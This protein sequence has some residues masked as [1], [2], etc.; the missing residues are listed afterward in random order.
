MSLLVVRSYNYPSNTAD[1]TEQR[2]HTKQNIKFEF[3][4]R[5]MGA[6]VRSIGERIKPG[7][8]GSQRVKI[9]LLD[10]LVNPSN[11]TPSI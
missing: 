2:R 3:W 4:K 8:S 6:W 10:P 1:K 9:R 11:S 5:M 7:E